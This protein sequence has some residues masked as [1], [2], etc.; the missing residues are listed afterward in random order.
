MS[1]LAQCW[2]HWL[3]GDIVCKWRKKLIF[4]I[5]DISLWNVMTHVEFS[6]SLSIFHALLLIKPSPLSSFVPHLYPFLA[7]S[8]HPTCWS[9]Y[10]TRW[11][12][13]YNA[14]DGGAAQKKSWE[15]HRCLKL[16]CFTQQLQTDHDIYGKYREDTD[17]VFPSSIHLVLISI[18]GPPWRSEA[19]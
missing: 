10:R 9:C 2:L 13:P 5:M 4:S 14:T 16:I 11:C 7:P 17:H 18:H 8:D 19:D 12:E 6:P 15:S 3:Q 1:L